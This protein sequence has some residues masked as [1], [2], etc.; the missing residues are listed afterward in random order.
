MTM[1]VGSTVRRGGTGFWLLTGPFNRGLGN[2][3]AVQPRFIPLTAVGRHSGH[4][5]YPRSEENR[6]RTSNA[7][8]LV[9]FDDFTSGREPGPLARRHTFE[10][11]SEIRS[12]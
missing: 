7:E 4:G 12:V 10:G 3:R 6:I 5:S 2:E 11:S 1:V 8:L 9:S